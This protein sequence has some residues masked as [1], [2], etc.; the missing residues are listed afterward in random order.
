[1]M[2]EDENKRNANMF[3][4]AGAS[5]LINFINNHSV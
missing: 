5:N 4:N 2:V 3:K 1:M